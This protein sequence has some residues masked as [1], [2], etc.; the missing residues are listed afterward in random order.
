VTISLAAG[1]L[2][3]LADPTVEGVYFVTDDGRELRFFIEKDF[4]CIHP[5]GSG[6]LEPVTPTFKAPPGFA[7]RK[8]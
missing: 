6:G 1:D 4:P 8:A 2:A 3:Q 7:A 5:R